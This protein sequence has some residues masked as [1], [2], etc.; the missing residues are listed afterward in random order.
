MKLC[1]VLITIILLDKLMVALDTLAVYVH[2]NGSVLIACGVLN[3]AMWC[4]LMVLLLSG[5]S[6][7]F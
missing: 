6:I 3:E 4:F 7:F 2:V 1:G 5:A